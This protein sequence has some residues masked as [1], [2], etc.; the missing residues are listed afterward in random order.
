MKKANRMKI[1]NWILIVLSVAFLVF[2]AVYSIRQ[3]TT[4]RNY[5]EIGRDEDLVI[6]SLNVGK[7]DCSILAYQGSFG[8]IDTGTRDAYD[9]IDKVL[10]L[11]H[12][13][14]IDYLI[15]THYDKDHVGSAV[16]LLQN[17]NVKKLYLPAYV[18]SKSGYSQLQAE[19]E[20]NRNVVYVSEDELITVNDMTIRVIPPKEPEAL[21]ADPDKMDNNMSL[22]CMVTLK[23]RR[24]LFTGDIEESRIRQILDR[25]DD[26]HADWLKVP[27]HGAYLSNS[28]EFLTAVSP[29]YAVISTGNERPADA[30]LLFDM[31]ELN[32]QNYTTVGGSIATVS[33]GD[34]ITVSYLE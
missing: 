16:K 22:M 7:A 21:Q 32:I 26:V 19:I 6:A 30:R 2:T 4:E 17:Y 8:L 11:N 34:S 28:R 12:E 5:S 25:K 18:S 24:F 29:Q 10:S 1:I 20:G 33:D 23:N 31:A 13:Q 15:I 9:L 14:T 3:E 27:Y